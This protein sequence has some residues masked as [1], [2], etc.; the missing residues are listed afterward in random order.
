MTVRWE[1]ETAVPSS[2]NG[3]SRPRAS[4]KRHQRQAY[5]VNDEPTIKGRLHN[6]DDRSSR[7]MTDN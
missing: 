7:L 1:T 3:C 6:I 5:D 4:P 2:T